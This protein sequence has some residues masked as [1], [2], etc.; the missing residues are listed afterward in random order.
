MNLMIAI[1]ALIPVVLVGGLLPWMA[2]SQRG[3][4]FG[5]TVPLEFAASNAAAMAIRR[6]R[7]RSAALAVT[8]LVILLLVLVFGN[9]WLLPLLSA[10]ALF[11]ELLGGLLL[12]QQ[13][14]RAML[15]HAAIVP[16]ARSAELLPKRHLGGLYASLAALLPLLLEAV[17]LRAHWELIPAS[18]PQHWNAYG[19]VDGWGHR[20]VAGVF[21]PILMGM[22]IVLVMTAIA[23]FLALA[24]GPQSKQRRLALVPL[25]GLA[26]LMAGTFCVVGF[27]P[28]RHSVSMET[29]VA[30][31][32][33]HLVAT[34]G[35]VVWLLVRSGIMNTSPAAEPYDSTPDAKW[36]GGL[37]Y[38]NP[39]DAAVIVPK[40]YGFGWTLNFARP[41]AWM[42]LGGMALVAALVGIAPF[43]LRR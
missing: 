35:V 11:V 20:S 21:F 24:S 19:H 18:W 15:P 13:E 26:W 17:W 37:I 42:Y 12:W 39:G 3:L 41:V 36:R 28:L 5:V 32:M 40:R 9:P 10:G 29:I 1:L 6:Y 23:A 27:L 38:Y 14:R 33:V 16:L 31:A 22:V 7:I 4:L 25:A 43:L 34:L 30:L 8:V 2:R